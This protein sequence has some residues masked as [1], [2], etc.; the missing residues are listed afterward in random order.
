MSR[1]Q[2][3]RL[4]LCAA[5]IGALAIAAFI[6]VPT[7]AAEEAVVIPAPTADVTL[8][9]YAVL[10][11]D[12]EKLAEEEWDIVILD[13]GQAIKNLGSQT[14]RAAFGLKGK[15]RVLL[16]G[17]PVENRLEEL[18]SDVPAVDVDAAAV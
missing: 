17:T 12:A 5:A 15:F 16:S 11:L 2:L 1:N 3:S 14:A 8:M 7:R 9:T 10:R 18:W 13:E 4:S 6:S